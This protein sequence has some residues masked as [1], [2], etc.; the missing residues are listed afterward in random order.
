MTQSEDRC[1]TNRATQTPQK[2]HFLIKENILISILHLNLLQ[3]YKRTSFFKMGTILNILLFLTLHSF[4]Y[5]TNSKSVKRE[6]KKDSVCV[7]Y[8]EIS[9]AD[10]LTH[11]YTN[12][13]IN[14]AGIIPFFLHIYVAFSFFLIFFYAASFY[15]NLSMLPPAT[16]QEEET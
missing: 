6:R 14:Q 9:H 7:F 3:D 5:T 10:S 11:F 13:K 12:L 16:E 4:M 1:L 2:Y 8:N 15:F